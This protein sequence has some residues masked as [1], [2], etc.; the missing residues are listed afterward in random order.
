MRTALDVILSRFSVKEQISN[1]AGTIFIVFSN[2]RDLKWSFS[3]LKS[4]SLLNS[5]HG[6][7]ISCQLRNLYPLLIKDCK[8]TYWEFVLVT[9]LRIFPITTKYFRS[10]HTDKIL[11]GYDSQWH[12]WLSMSHKWTYE[13]WTKSNVKNNQS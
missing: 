13:K 6:I 1:Y 8:H 2:F 5:P 4:F 12:T 7:N 11:F 3:L 10:T 9:Y